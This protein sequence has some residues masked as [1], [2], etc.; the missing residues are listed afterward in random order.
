MQRFSY[1]FFLVVFL[2]AQEDHGDL[3]QIP[4]ETS[5]ISNRRTTLENMDRD[6]NHASASNLM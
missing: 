4:G 6:H 5:S 3:R 1:F 2:W